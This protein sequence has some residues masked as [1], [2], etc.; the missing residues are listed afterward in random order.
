MFVP[1][2][3][4]ATDLRA[5]LVSPKHTAKQQQCIEFYYYMYGAHVG[6]L[7]VYFKVSRVFFN[8]QS[9]SEQMFALVLLAENINAIFFCGLLLV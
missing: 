8:T 3:V 2:S 9:I 4:T 7:N 1:A 6:I 5:R